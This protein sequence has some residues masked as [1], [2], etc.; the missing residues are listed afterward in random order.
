MPS[1]Y[2]FLE[3]TD[4]HVLKPSDAAL[5]GLI[6]EH[7]LNCAVSA[8]NA[9]YG[10]RPLPLDRL[11][12]IQLHNSSNSNHGPKSFTLHSLA[13]KPLDMPLAHAKVNLRGH[14]FSDDTLMWDV[15]FPAGFH[16][17]L[18]VDIA[19]FS[20]QVWD[21][22]E[23]LQMWVDFHHSG[24]TMDWEFCLDDLKVSFQP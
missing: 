19:A 7:D 2:S 11:P 14:Q 3:F 21:Q 18:D 16:D 22:L 10:A 15:D 4:F 1:N 23:T 24:T 8:P 13:V 6:S 5:K 17:I 9:L 12:R 20:G